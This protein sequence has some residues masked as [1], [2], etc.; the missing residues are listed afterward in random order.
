MENEISCARCSKVVCISSHP[1]QADPSCP[2]K[3]R[4][5]IIKE[6]LTEYRKPNISEFVR[7][8]SVQ[9][10]ECYMNLPEGRTTRH[11][12]VEETIQ[13]AKKMNYKK[14]GVAFCNGLRNETQI[15]NTILE[16]RGFEVTSVCCKVGALPKETIGITEEQK[17]AGPGKFESMCNPITQAEILNQAGTE[18]N[19]MVGLCVGHDSLF[20]KYIQGLTTVLIV[21]D[22]VFGHNPAAAL[23]QSNAYYRKL[24]RKEK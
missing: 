22:R 4:P 12:R 9:E 23:Y 24:M 8:A 5:D 19:I 17:I 3:T 16:N 21:K 7:L 2:M 15:L 18:F 13:F 14:L 11:P 20:M 1:D 6:A 10:F